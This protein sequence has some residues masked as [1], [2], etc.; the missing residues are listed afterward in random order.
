[1]TSSHVIGWLLYAVLG[2]TCVIIWAADWR[3]GVLS[4]L[5]VLLILALAVRHTPNPNPKPKDTP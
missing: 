5:V 2:W 4:V 3:Y 1:M